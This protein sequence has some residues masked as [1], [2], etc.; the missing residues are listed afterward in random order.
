MGNWKSSK[1][2][3]FD[4]ISILIG[5]NLL[6]LSGQTAW[7]LL[8]KATTSL[9]TL[10]I[11]GMVSR[12]YGASGTGIFTLA[13]T[14]LTFFYLATD[15]GVN[16]H[17]IQRFM[18]SNLGDEWRR[19]LGFRIFL[20]ILMAVLANTIVFLWPGI[21]EIFKQSI[22]IGTAAIF[23]S[24][25]F[26][27]SSAIFQSKLRYDFS[28]IAL[29]LGAFLSLI[30]S[31][32]VVSQNLGIQYL[33]I[34][35]MAG[36]L[37]CG[38]LALYFTSQFVKVLPI[39]DFGY[40]KQLISESWPISATLILN[41]IY[42]RV[43]GFIL[44]ALKPLA[45]VGIYNLAYQ[46][47]QAFLV[48]PTFI[49]NSFYPMMLKVFYEDK[50]KFMGVLVKACVVMFGLAFLGTIMVAAFSRD[51]VALIS[52]GRDFSGSSGA[53]IMLS[54]GFPAFFV[55]AVLMWTLIVLKKYKIM[56]LVYFIG[57]LVNGFL[58]LLLIPQFSYLAAAL[59][60]VLSEYLIL[61]AQMIILIRVF[62]SAEF[63]K[64]IPAQSTI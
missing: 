13:L 14:Y 16:A 12:M 51:M 55:S 43:D 63:K 6:T 42:F 47:F 45:D 34:A 48:L 1:S 21:N 41:V 59:V 24:A 61:I 57:F 5:S 17:V 22:F 27:T 23:G 20:A 30:L 40:I 50:S 11:L 18:V 26:T 54:L 36:W 56:L 15:F 31:Y 9:S 39:F 33:L 29:G 53:L 62:F 52:G 8:G 35:Q 60:T 4:K 28:T 64:T 7:Q 58:N 19:L 3:I 38:F 10:I 37:L 32:A 25:L 49:M 44:S 46:I 2:F